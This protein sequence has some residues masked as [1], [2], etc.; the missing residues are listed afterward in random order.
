[1]S[2]GLSVPR[3]ATFG[4][5]SFYRPATGAECGSPS[6]GVV[7]ISASFGPGGPLGTLGLLWLMAGVHNALQLL[8]RAATHSETDFDAKSH[9]EQGKQHCGVWW[10][11]TTTPAPPKVILISKF[12]FL[13]SVI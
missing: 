9:C 2:A 6:E 4:S 12:S 7:G 3:H 10:C 11:S 13:M 5:H 8:K 1:M